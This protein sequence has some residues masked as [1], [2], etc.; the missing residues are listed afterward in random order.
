MGHPDV[1]EKEERSNDQKESGE[2]HS[3]PADGFVLIHPEAICQGGKDERS[4]AQTGEVEVHGDIK[5]EC[6]LVEDVIQNLSIHSF[7]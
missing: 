2:D 1:N 6:F 4:C 5:A 7:P 3:D